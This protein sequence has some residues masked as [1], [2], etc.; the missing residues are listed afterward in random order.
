MLTVDPEDR[1]IRDATL[2]VEG[3][4]LLAVGPA[5]EVARSFRPVPGDGSIDGAGLGATPGSSTRTFI[6]PRR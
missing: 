6:C 4:R 1:V 5:D 2:V 3:D